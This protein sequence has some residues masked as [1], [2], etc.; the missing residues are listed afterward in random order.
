M[1][2][3]LRC[4]C[5][6]AEG[7]KEHRERLLGYEEWIDR[8]CVCV[9]VCVWMDAPSRIPDEKAEPQSSGSR[10]TSKATLAQP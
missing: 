9:C 2:G 1:L 3:V 4:R 8:A 6:G 7:A 10:R 5:C